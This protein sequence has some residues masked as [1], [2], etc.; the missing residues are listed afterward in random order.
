MIIDI[1]IWLSRSFSMKQVF[2]NDDGY[3]ELKPD[4]WKWL[5]SS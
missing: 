3:D 1:L 4:C 2:A 5:S